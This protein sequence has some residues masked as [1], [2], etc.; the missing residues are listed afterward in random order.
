MSEATL[1]ER[2]LEISARIAS[3]EY[4]VKRALWNV[5]APQC[6]ENIDAIEEIAA[7]REQGN[8]ALRSATFPSLSPAVSDHVAAMAAQHVDRVLS[9]LIEEMAAVYGIRKD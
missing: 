8:E 2:Y 9:E 3:V 1:H 4:L 5:I 7:F 6:E